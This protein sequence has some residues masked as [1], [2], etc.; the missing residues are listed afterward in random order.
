MRPLRGWDGPLSLGENGYRYSKTIGWIKLYI[1]VNGPEF[2][3]GVQGIGQSFEV[4][5]ERGEWKRYQTDLAQNSR[6][7]IVIR[8]VGGT[9][10]DIVLERVDEGERLEDGI[11]SIED[12][13]DYLERSVSC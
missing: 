7:D 9:T 10:W 8:L 11:C 2:W 12:L 1:D 6:G 3:G 4:A 13:A 5:Q